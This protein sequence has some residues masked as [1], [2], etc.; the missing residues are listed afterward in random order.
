MTRLTATFATALFVIVIPGTV[1]GLVPWWISHWRMSAPLLGFG[2]F[3]AIGGFCIICGTPVLLDSFARFALRGLGTPAPLLPTEHL[4]T[5]GL[6]RYVRNPM[7][8]AVSLLIFGQGLLLGS[9]DVLVYGLCVC[10]AFGFFV[11]LYEE[12]TLRKSFG[13]EYDEFCANVPR[14]FPRLTPWKGSPIRIHGKTGR[15]SRG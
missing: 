5:T 10:A 13:A 8:V 12:P 6:Y 9:E 2:G 1:V 3:R 7:Y 15:M 11:W 4:V 14:W